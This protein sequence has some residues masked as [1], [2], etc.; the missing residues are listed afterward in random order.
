LVAKLS[1]ID[2]AVDV[3]G[4]YGGSANDFFFLPADGESAIGLTRHLSTIDN[5]A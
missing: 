4:M 1:A 5:L 2:V 3:D